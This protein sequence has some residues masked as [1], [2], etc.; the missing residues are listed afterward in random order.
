MR[1]CLRTTRLRGGA[2]TALQKP[3]ERVDSAV[4]NNKSVDENLPDAAA[5]SEEQRRERFERDAMQYVD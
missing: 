2:G 1:G 3:V 5:E 4:M